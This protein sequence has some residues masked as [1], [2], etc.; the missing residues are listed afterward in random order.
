M[1]NHS[2]HITSH[3][4]ASAEVGFKEQPSCTLRVVWDILRPSEENEAGDNQVP[5]ESEATI[6]STTLY[7]GHLDGHSDLINIYRRV[8]VG[9]VPNQIIV[10]K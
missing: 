5:D 6:P 2:N 7:C 3:I 4:L 9:G 10:M 8:P 1:T